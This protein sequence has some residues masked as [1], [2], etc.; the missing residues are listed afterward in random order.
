M[1]IDQTTFDIYQDFVYEKTAKT[2]ED[3]IAWSILGL[4]SEAGEVSAVLEKAWRKRG[5]LNEDDISKLFDELGDVMWFLAAVA[6]S[7]DFSLDDIM[8]HNINKL[9]QRASESTLLDS[10]NATDKKAN[11]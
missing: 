11:D 4:T 8:M 6:N 10:T 5:H 3:L 7:L 9:N 2:P 1:I